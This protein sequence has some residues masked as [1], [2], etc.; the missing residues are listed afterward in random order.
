MKLQRQRELE[1]IAFKERSRKLKEKLQAQKSKMPENLTHGCTEKKV[2]H[3]SRNPSHSI[4]YFQNRDLQLL[5]K[6]KE[7]QESNSLAAKQKQERLEKLKPKVRLAYIVCECAQ[8]TD[9]TNSRLTA[10]RQFQG[11]FGAQWKGFKHRT[12]TETQDAKLEGELIVI[13]IL[14]TANSDGQCYS[15]VQFWIECWL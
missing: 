10:A 1:E 11:K 14:Q 8:Q 3:I 6:Q 15:R 5:Q 2:G 12:H 4:K 7:T 13:H 9:G